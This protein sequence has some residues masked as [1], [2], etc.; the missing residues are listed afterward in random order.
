MNTEGRENRAGLEQRVRLLEAELEAVQGTSVTWGE[1]IA[2]VLGVLLLVVFFVPA[3]VLF[4]TLFSIGACMHVL[5][6]LFG[7]REQQG[8]GDGSPDVDG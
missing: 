5:E 1:L 3:V 6:A 2:T 8:S 7:G 4:I